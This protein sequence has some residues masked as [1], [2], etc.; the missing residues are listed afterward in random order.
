M[1]GNVSQSNNTPKTALKFVVLLGVVSLFS[2]ITYEG[3]RSIHGPFL[4]LLGASAATVGVVAGLG[5]MVAYALRLVFGYLSDRTGRYWTI[6]IV[7]YIL[8]LFAVPALA[9]AGNWPLAAALMVAER[10]GKAVRSPARDAMLS[11]AAHHMGRGWAFG[12]HE[13]LDQIG[14]VTGP[15]VVAAVMYFKSDYRTSYAVLIIPALMAM[16]VLLA[17]RWLHPTP[18]DME[19]SPEHHLEPQGIPRV[20]WLYLVASAL[21]AAGFADYPL[22]AYHFQ[23]TGL[24]PKTWIPVFYAVAM[25]VDALAALWLGR[26]YDRKGLSVM[27][28]V[29]L[30]S[31]L[32]APLVF[33]GGFWLVLAGMILWGVGM[34]AQESVMRAAVAGMTTAGKRGSAYGLFS[35]GY[36]VAWFLGSATMGFLYDWS[37]TALVAFS[38]V[39]QLL[40]APLLLMVSRRA[41][42]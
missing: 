2:D 39:M 17:A 10:L 34:A 6:T 32:V 3:A 21:I 41:R 14:A 23:K 31:A 29:A 20:F 4:A 8:N 35:A 5:E 28:G 42:S 9:L 16:A 36:G 26:R 15:L 25:G 33:L 13:A 7:G 11:H 30:L 12:L 38:V 37:V 24:I 18:R 40:S 1:I 19:D 22:A 27:V